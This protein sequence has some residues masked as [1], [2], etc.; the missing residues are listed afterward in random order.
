MKK[1]NQLPTLVSGY[2]LS[3]T[4]LGEVSMVGYD[5]AGEVGRGVRV[6]QLCVQRQGNRKRPGSFG[7]QHAESCWSGKVSRDSGEGKTQVI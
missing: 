6:G 5:G 7:K 1:P 2:L 3:S 4:G